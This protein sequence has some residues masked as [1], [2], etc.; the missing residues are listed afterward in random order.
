MSKEKT[1]VFFSPNVIW[2][3]RNDV[4]DYLEFQRT[5]DLGKYLGLPIFHKSPN[6]QTFQFVLEKVNQR[7]SQWKARNLSLAGRVTLTKSVLQALPLYVM[8][9]SLLPKSI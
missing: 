6:K 5:E 2:Q 9:T 4:S 1:R 3:N 7:L 8:Q